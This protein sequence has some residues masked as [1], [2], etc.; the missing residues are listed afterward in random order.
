MERNFKQLLF[1]F[2]W[3]VAIL[4][5]V[6][7]TGFVGE[8][9]VLNRIEQF[10][11]KQRLQN[12]IDLYKQKFEEDRETLTKLKEDPDAIVEVA[13]GRYYMKTDDEDIFIVEDKVDDEEE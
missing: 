8:N 2:K 1:H 3:L 10:Q 7:F 11:E 12:E 13:R 4:I 5:F 6:I 9:C